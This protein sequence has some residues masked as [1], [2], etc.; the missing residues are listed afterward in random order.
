MKGRLFLFLFA[1]PFA[2]FGTW[3]LWLVG[4]ELS[5]AWVMRSWEPVSAELERAG[6]ETR[7]GDD[8]DTY[9]AYASY[10]YTYAFV[11]YT[12]DRVSLS[13]W[14]DNIGNYQRDIGRRLADALARGEAIEI[15]VDP[16]E[17]SSSIIDREPRWGLIAFKSVFVLLFGGV[18]YGLAIAAF[19]RRPAPDIGDAVVG[20]TPWLANP[21]WQ[22]APLR[23]GSRAAMWGAWAFAALWNLV[24]MPLPFLLYPEVTEKAN[25][26]ALLGLIFPIVGVGLLVWAVRRTAEW[27][28]FGASPLTLDPFPGAIGGHV[29]GRIEMN[30]PYSSADRFELTLTCV[31]SRISGSGKNRS[32]RETARWQDHRLAYTEPGS[33]G[34]RLAFRFDVP[35]DLDAA[36]ASKASDSYT[37]WRL[38]LE[39]ETAHGKVDRSWELPVYPT[40]ES[41]RN[42]DERRLGEAETAQARADDSSLLERLSLRQTPR[43]RSLYYPMG[44]NLGSSLMG[45]LI[46]AVFAGAGVF[47]ILGEGALFM[48]SVFTLIGSAIALGSVY[49]GG[50]SLEVYQDGISLYSRRR[51]FGLPL[52]QKSMHRAAFRRFDTRTGLKAQSGGKHTVYYSVH[53]VGAAEESL[54]LGEGFRGQAEAKAAIRLIARELGLPL[55]DE[56]SARDDGSLEYNALAADN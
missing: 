19:L 8:S 15:W 41:S 30:L 9:L 5:D 18:G 46:G 50:N 48:G 29:G 32:R 56:Q 45:F 42:I 16:N 38:G 20:D 35:E 13:S 25:Y 37:I 2:S 44:R 26:A 1:L 36:D 34:T 21:A 6:V 33:T 28:R 3:M 54:T 53:A 27:R 7:R 11:S 12:G 49:M 17:P 23:S 55:P 51:I 14:A 10:R 47:L 39:A 31:R 4:S 40:G 22:G 52:K 43:G 24:S